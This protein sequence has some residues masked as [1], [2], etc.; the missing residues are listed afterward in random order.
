MSCGNCETCNCNNK[1]K[2]ESSLFHEF[3]KLLAVVLDKAE[4][5]VFATVPNFADD[6]YFKVAYNVLDGL[7]EIRPHYEFEDYSDAVNMMGDNSTGNIYD[8]H[9]K[10]VA[11]FKLNVITGEWRYDY[12]FEYEV[13]NEKNSEFFNEVESSVKSNIKDYKLKR[14]ILRYIS[15]IE[16]YGV[17]EAKKN[18]Y[19]S[20]E[21]AHLLWML[22]EI[23][24]KAKRTLLERYMFLG[25]IQGVLRAKNIID[26]RHE[27]DIMHE[28]V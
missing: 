5:T 8:E 28:L 1:F 4:Y 19:G 22:K 18:E 26:V 25:Y 15:I 14:L 27:R 2:N 20:T 21:L 12:K 24:P 7:F 3:Q 10:L 9:G 11:A 17:T 16:C 13:L 23:Y 6:D